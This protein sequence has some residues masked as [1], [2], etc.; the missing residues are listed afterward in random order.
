M[1]TSHFIERFQQTLRARKSLLCVGLDPDLQKLPANLPRSAEGLITFCKEIIAATH[2]FAAAFKVN[3]AFFE[4]LG[5]SGWAALEAVAAAL[6]DDVIR[7]ADAKRGDIGH[8]AQ[9]YAEA[10]FRQLPFDAMTA[11]P[12]LGEDAAQPFLEDATKG[13]FFL[14]R[15]SN[16]GSSDIQNFPDRTRPLYLHIAAQV[17]EWNK[18][19]NAGLVVGATHPRELQEVRKVSPDLPFLIPGVGAQGGDL[20]TAVRYGAA[21]TGDLAI[22]NASRTVLYADSGKNFSAAAARAAEKMRNDMRAILRAMIP[23]SK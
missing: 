4:A 6:P 9:M 3:F 17:R 10:I 5:K 7:I 14:C 15:T 19:G 2:D 1:Q 22:I 8:T 16:P 21:V 23:Q 12:Y 20:E 13:I 18:N 11:N